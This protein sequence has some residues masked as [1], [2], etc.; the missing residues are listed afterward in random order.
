M[1]LA[2]KA[3]TERGKPIIKTGNEYIETLYSLTGQD[4]NNFRVR[5][6]NDS[7]TGQIHFIVESH[8]FGKWKETVNEVKYTNI[9]KENGNLKHG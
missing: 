8:F 2:I 1:K 6:I 4:S 9:T 7:K 3:I 5:V